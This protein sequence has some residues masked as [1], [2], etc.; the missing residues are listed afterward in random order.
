MTPTPVDPVPHVASYCAATAGAVPQRPA[1]QGHVD[2]DV[3]IV[4]AGYTGLSTAIHL[5]EAGLRVVVLESARV[6]WGASG[7]NGVQ[8]V[9]SYS[10]DLDVIAQRHGAETWRSTGPS[11]GRDGLRGRRDHPRA[12]GPP[13]H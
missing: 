12:R 6:G 11:A 3:C 9:H 5:A 4:G 7:C 8:I 2:A 10:R 1:L 13:C